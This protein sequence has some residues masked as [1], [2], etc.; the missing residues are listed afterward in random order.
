MRVE[1]EV[2]DW[3]HECCG[4]EIERYRRVRW[5]CGTHEGRLFETHHDLEGI[6]VQEVVGTVVHIEAVLQ[7]G[8]RVAIDRIPSGDAMR[9][10]DPH[11]DGLILE[12]YTGEPVDAASHDLIFIVTVDTRR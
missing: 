7:D 5:T 1:V 11:D 12:Q 3:E 2:G 6:S 4:D 8:T 9:G 10:C